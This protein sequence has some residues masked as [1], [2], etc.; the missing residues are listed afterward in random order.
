MDEKSIAL[1]FLDAVA[2]ADRSA[3]DAAL[4]A[5][6]MWWFPPS[7]AEHGMPRPMTGR[8]AILDLLS[9][10]QLYEARSMRW[11]PRHV[12]SEG[13]IVVVHAAL[14]ALPIEGGEYENEYVFVYR[15]VDAAI[16][17]C[18]EHTDTLYASARVSHQPR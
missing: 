15:I 1:R 3:M 4:G 5:D 10:L 7:A 8:E 16:V 2:A 13:D 12:V 9:T 6:P 18:W 17:K 11:K 14:S